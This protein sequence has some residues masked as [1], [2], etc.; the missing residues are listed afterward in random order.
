M[1]WIPHDVIRNQRTV[2]GIGK[3]WR[4]KKNLESSIPSFTV[5][6]SVLRELEECF[7]GEVA[8]VGATYSMEVEMHKEGIFSLQVF[9][10]GA[11]LCLLK[12]KV[13]GC[14][15]ATAIEH[16]QWLEERFRSISQWEPSKVDE[17]RVTWVRCF[18]IPVH[19]WQQQ[20]FDF[21]IKPYGTVLGIA[22]A[23]CEKK[24]LDVAC[25]KIA[26]KSQE[27]INQLVKVSINQKVFAIR[28]VEDVT[29]PVQT[30]L[31]DDREEWGEDS[32]VS[33]FEDEI[34]EESLGELM[35]GE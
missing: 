2:R 35:R 22:D 14:M 23:T 15:D 5:V 19:G 31:R 32:S 20:F 21:I 34:V 27:T 7:V 30:Q 10:M 17:E 9:P 6:S 24:C 18:G 33:G 13:K 29:I 12:E 1:V 26:T 25:L 3:Q 28:I 8:D 4:Q 11:N 16:K